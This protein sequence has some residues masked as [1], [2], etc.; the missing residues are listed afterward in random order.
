MRTL[1]PSGAHPAPRRADRGG[2]RPASWWHRGAWTGSAVLWRSGARL[3][4][5]SGI[6]AGGAQPGARAGAVLRGWRGGWGRSAA[7]RMRALAHAQL[8]YFGSKMG[9]LGVD[10]P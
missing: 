7:H 5:G 10:T 1:D 3:L 6:R 2:R 8:S 4:W 9:Q